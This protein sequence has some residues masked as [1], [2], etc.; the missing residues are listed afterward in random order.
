M[1]RISLN[2]EAPETMTPC[3][4]YGQDTLRTIVSSVT[5]TVLP[6]VEGN[7]LFTPQGTLREK[8]KEKVKARKV[9]PRKVKPKILVLK[10][11]ETAGNGAR[12]ANAVETMTARGL[13]VTRQKIETKIQENKMEHKAEGAP[14]G[15]KNLQEEETRP[16]TVKPG[17]LQLKE[18]N[19]M[20]Q[21]RVLL[22]VNLLVVKRIV[23]LVFRFLKETALKERVAMTCIPQNAGI[24]ATQLCMANALEE[25]TVTFCIHQIAKRHTMPSYR[26]L[27]PRRK[28]SSPTC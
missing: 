9:K 5:L 11:P 7:L 10:G 26:L 16:Q 4:A 3:E 28:P 12:K 1:S 8:E 14:T 2:A 6:E 15:K 18:N 25:R 24:I 23:P 17:A 21:R 20:L 13:K 27:T 19:N 22:E